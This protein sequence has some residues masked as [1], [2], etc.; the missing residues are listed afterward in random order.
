MINFNQHFLA[1][2]HQ[3]K[4]STI[5][6]FIYMLCESFFSSWEQ[7]PYPTPIQ[8]HPTLIKPDLY[9]ESS[10]PYTRPWLNYFNSTLLPQ[11]NPLNIKH[12]YIRETTT[13]SGAQLYLCAHQ[14]RTHTTF[15]INHHGLTWT[16]ATKL[17]RHR[18][19]RSAHADWCH[20]RI[21]NKELRNTCT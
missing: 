3:H 13:D 2:S 6:L 18:Q 14:V 9:K 1:N 19:S 5:T 17:R 8:M 12:I 11:P 20:I 21:P 10:K 16:P 7:P 15:Y 4:T